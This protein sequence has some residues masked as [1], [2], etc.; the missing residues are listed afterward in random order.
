M[1]NWIVQ[2]IPNLLVGL[3]ALGAVTLAVVKIV[4][5]KRAHRGGCACGCDGCPS[6]DAC[7]GRDGR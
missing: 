6:A 3:A 5:D 4:R 1:L 7:H 2:N